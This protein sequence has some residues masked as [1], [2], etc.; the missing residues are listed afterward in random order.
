[1]LTLSASTAGMILLI[2]AGAGLFSYA[3]TDMRLPHE[4]FNISRRWSL[5]VGSYLLRNVFLLNAGHVPR[6]DLRHSDH[7]AHFDPCSRRQISI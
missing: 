7:H 1:M 6:G 4:V 2:I 5:R 3:I